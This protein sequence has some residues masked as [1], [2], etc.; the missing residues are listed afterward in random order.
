MVQGNTG[1]YLL[2]SL[3]RIRS[4]LRRPELAAVDLDAAATTPI[5]LEHPAVCVA[6]MLWCIR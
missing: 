2:Y 3:T 1:V 5:V 4:I 6:I